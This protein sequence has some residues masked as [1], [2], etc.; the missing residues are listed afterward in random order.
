VAYQVVPT[1]RLA[2][3]P[4]ACAPA[5]PPPPPL[6][7]RAPAPRNSKQEYQVEYK[8]VR[9]GTF[10]AGPRVTLEEGST[11]VVHIGR[12]LNLSDGTVQDLVN[13]VAAANPKNQVALGH[14]FG[15]TVVTLADDMIRADLTISYR[16]VDSATA[17]GLVVV[18]KTYRVVQKLKLGNVVKVVLEKDHAGN[19]RTQLE[20]KVTRGMADVAPSPT[21]AAAT[22]PL[23][24]SY[25]DFSFTG[26]F[27]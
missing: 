23:S 14:E 26:M 19:P 13:P 6:P 2:V 20:F 15:M 5:D 24:S 18:G 4:P 3:A 22:S 11:A 25:R 21:R 8:L 12:P 17:D 9:K 27:R 16:E 7:P 10:W 1:A